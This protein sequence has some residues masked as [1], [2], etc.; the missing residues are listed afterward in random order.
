[1][2]K[3]LMMAALMVLTLS[4]AMT[5]CSK[6]DENETTV[7]DNLSQVVGTWICTASSDSWT[8]EK[9]SG[10]GENLLVGQTLTIKSDGTYSSSS[11]DFGRSGTWNVQGGNFSA[12]SSSGRVMSG[13]ISLDGGQMRLK[14]STTDGYKFDYKF[15]K[16]N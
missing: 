11:Y 8:T 15:S 16:Q 4:M 5:S 13:T 2:K 7:V 3:I 14:G 10:S 9:G 1:M 12:S 6:D